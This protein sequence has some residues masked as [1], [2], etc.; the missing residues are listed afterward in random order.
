M[1]YLVVLSLA[2]A[3]CACVP[4]TLSKHVL[5]DVQSDRP[6]FYQTPSYWNR[7]QYEPDYQNNWYERYFQK[8]MPWQQHREDFWNQNSI[9]N[10]W[11]NLKRYTEFSDEELLRKMF[12]KYFPEYYPYGE[13][14]N[15]EKVLPYFQQ[16]FQ[17]YQ[18]KQSDMRT[19]WS[20]EQVMYHIFQDLYENYERVPYNREQ[21]M[22]HIMKYG[23][24]FPNRP[25][26]QEDLVQWTEFVYRLQFHVLP[27]LKQVESGSAMNNYEQR[28]DQT[29]PWTRFFNYLDQGKMGR[30]VPYETSYHQ[31]WEQPLEWTEKKGQE[32]RFPWNKYEKQQ[33]DLTDQWYDQ[34]QV[35]Q[36]WR[37]DQEEYYPQTWWYGK[38]QEPQVWSWKQRSTPFYGQQ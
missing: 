19:T 5:V 28:F 29:N 1:K 9:S 8:Y 31:R 7:Q 27:Y 10:E 26:S 23:N 33:F 32:W 21:I 16:Y 4:V 36:V 14:L 38:Q 15:Y 37:W 22:N 24:Y 3:Y 18:Q 2:V 17:R 13:T 30:E 20:F 35:P 12:V 6:Q 25:L 34:K 11:T